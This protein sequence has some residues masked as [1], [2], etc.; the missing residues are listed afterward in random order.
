[1]I[2]KTFILLLFGFSIHF[3]S[4]CNNQQ[5]QGQ[6]TKQET[7]K[8]QQEATTKIIERPAETTEVIENENA[9]KLPTSFVY[10]DVEI[11][12]I[13]E[14]TKQYKSSKAGFTF[15]YPGQLVY[16]RNSNIDAFYTTEDWEGFSQQKTDHYYWPQFTVTFFEGVSIDEAITSSTPLDKSSYYERKNDIRE[17]KMIG[18]KT[19]AMVSALNYDQSGCSYFLRGQENNIIHVSTYYACGESELVEEVLKSMLN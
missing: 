3:L 14:K 17:D 10:D 7:E 15:Q 16:K 19:F 2:K 8:L 13:N 6:I 9:D 18:G 12:N 5:S 1:M 4:G 11:Q